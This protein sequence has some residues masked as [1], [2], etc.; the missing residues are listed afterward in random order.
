VWGKY[1]TG[2]LEVGG[3]AALGGRKRQ[4]KAARVGQRDGEDIADKQGPL[5]RETRERRPARECVNQ[6]ENVFP[7]KT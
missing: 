2:H 5:D 6:K 1:L 4:E 7:A 3:Q